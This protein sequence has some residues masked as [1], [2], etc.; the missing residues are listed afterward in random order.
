MIIRDLAQYLPLLTQYTEL[1][2]Q[3]NRVLSIA[4]MK[5]NLVQNVALL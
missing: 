5:G 4:F 3:E 2:S 1:R